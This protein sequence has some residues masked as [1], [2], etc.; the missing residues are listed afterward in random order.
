MQREIKHYVFGF[1]RSSCHLMGSP[2]EGNDLHGAWL[3]RGRRRSQLLLRRCAPFFVLFFPS[4][5]RSAFSFWLLRRA[6]PLASGTASWCIVVLLSAF[7]LLLYLYHCC[8]YWGH[9]YS[10]ITHS[11]S[12]AKFL[13]D[14]HN[15]DKDG[16]DGRGNHNIITATINSLQITTTDYFVS[17]M[18]S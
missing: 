10:V 4:F 7:C 15:P 17:S 13:I 12:L 5:P 16:G 2:I 9:H 3:S 6:W 18:G 14:I 11:S 8:Y 1:R